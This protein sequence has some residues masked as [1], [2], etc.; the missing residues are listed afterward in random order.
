[1]T[2]RVPLLRDVGYVVLRDAIGAVEL[3]E[4]FDRTM[5]DAF[6]HP[7]HMNVGA[8]GN[9]FRYVPM[10]CERTPVSLGNVVALAAVASQL[11][12]CMV[13]PGRAKA[14]TYVGSTQPHRD[15]DLALRSIGMAA[16]LE[17]LDAASGALVVHPGS[18][19]NGGSPSA[20]AAEAGD[21]TSSWV[22]LDTQ[23]GDLIVF[24]ERV[25]HA[26]DGGDIRRQWRV[27]FVADDAPDDVLAEWY[28]R[29]YSVGW[30]AGY[31]IGRYPSYGEHWRTLDAR[32]NDRLTELGAY[33]AA[34]S[35]EAAALAARHR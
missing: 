31:D 14:T 21:E 34:A 10:M 23:P 17:P 22:V 3:A 35:E 28:A 26:A 9:M 6:D 13:L 29:Q 27:D 8:A 4:E 32:W 20:T 1:M 12:G 5:D 30:D 11:L 19:R 16:Y 25:L 2:D 15:S 18:H 7:D 33:A 24:D